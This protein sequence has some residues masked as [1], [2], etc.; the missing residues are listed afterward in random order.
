Q[1]YVDNGFAR[2]TYNKH[3]HR[4]RR[5]FRWGV[6]NEL[7]KPSVWQSLAAVEPLRRGKTKARETTPVGPIADTVVQATLPHLPQVVSD[8]VSLQRLC[9]CRPQEVCLIRPCDVDSSGEV[10]VYVPPQHKTEH[11][12][13][14]RSIY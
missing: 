9:G 5:M 8:M 13:K 6:E 4:V 3:L 12:G 2:A 14:R 1:R 10:W 7:I 11:L